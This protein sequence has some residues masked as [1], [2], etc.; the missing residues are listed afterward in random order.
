MGTRIWET[1]FNRRD[2]L[3]L[4]LLVPGTFP[5]VQIRQRLR[6]AD[7]EKSGSRVDADLLLPRCAEQRLRKQDL[8]EGGNAVG[9]RRPDLG[10][11]DWM[12][13]L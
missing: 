12:R 8:A 5:P 13:H 9:V 11:H 7:P 3:Q 4:A 2:F 1:E 6:A 10:V